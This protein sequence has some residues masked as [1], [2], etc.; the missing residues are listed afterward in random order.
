MVYT[1][2]FVLLIVHYLIELDKALFLQLNT[3]SWLRADA[4]WIFMSSKAAWFLYGIPVTALFLF[5]ERLAFALRFVWVLLLFLLADQTANFFKNN[6]QRPRPCRDTELRAEMHFINER[7]SP[8]GYFSAHAANSM[9]LVVFCSLGMAALYP[10]RRL[11]IWVSGIVFSLLVSLSR[12][13]VGVHYPFDIASGW[14][15]GILCA[16]LLYRLALYVQPYLPA[17]LRGGL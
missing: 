10:R 4:F 11:W 8:Y 14:L 3:A 13:M 15:W 5:K 9:G 12:I 1:Q 6:I 17:R 2:N 16:L 7:C